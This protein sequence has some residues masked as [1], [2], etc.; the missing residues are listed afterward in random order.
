MQR[1]V[2]KLLTTSKNRFISFALS[3]LPL[4]NEVVYRFCKNYIDVFSGQNNGDMFT[5]GERRIVE[6]WLQK[7]VTVMDVGANV[8]EWSRLALSINPAI[9]LHCFEPCLSTYQELIKNDFPVNVVSNQFGLSSSERNAELF[10]FENHSGLNSIYR[11]EGLEAGYHLAPQSNRETVRLTTLDQYCTGA[12]ITLID[13]MKVDVEGHELEVFKGAS[14]LLSNNSIR[15]IQFEYGG[16]N[17][18]SRVLIKDIFEFFRGFPDYKI[19]KVFPTYLKDIEKYDQ[20]LEN[21]QYSNW[22]VI[23][24]HAAVQSYL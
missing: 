7:S 5:N 4:D 2:T 23:N 18:D 10:I 24:S 15:F 14:Q 16:C 8:G 1:S 12:R 9:N 6:E 17:I 19:F 22:A 21:F 3:L 11:R 13:F 20:R